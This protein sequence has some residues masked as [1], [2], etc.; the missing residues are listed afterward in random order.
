MTLGHPSGAF[1]TTNNT[2][3]RGAWGIYFDRQHSTTISAQPATCT[4]LKIQVTIYGNLN[5]ML[6]G[7]DYRVTLKGHNSHLTIL[8]IEGHGGFLLTDNTD[9]T[10][11]P[12]VL[13]Q[14]HVQC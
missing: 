5:V 13:N 2:D 4:V 1:F 6:S 14:Q 7:P 9:N 10:V 12:L 3:N 8:I 11:L